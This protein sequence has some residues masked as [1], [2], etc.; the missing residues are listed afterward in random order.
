MPLLE[1]LSV[2][3]TT[4]FLV[5]AMLS[6]SAMPQNFNQT[7]RLAYQGNT[8]SYSNPYFT[9]YDGIREHKNYIKSAELHQKSAHK[10]DA[11]AHT[12]LAINITIAKI[13][14]KIISKQ[15]SCIGK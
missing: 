12:V 13:C 1:S 14:L 15:V 10:G 3:K 4:I 2:S 11:R 5:V 8:I 6:A 9:Y 7:K